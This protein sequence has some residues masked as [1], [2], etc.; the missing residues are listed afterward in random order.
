MTTI[1]S[2][3]YSN[4]NNRTDRNID[5]YFN[6]GIPLL[7]A[8][9]SKIIF[10]DQE[11]YDKIYTYENENTRI[12][13]TKKEDIYLYEYTNMLEN[14]QL[15]TTYPVKDTIEY[16]FIMCNKTESIRKAIELNF[17]NTENFTWIDFGI[18]HVFKNDT[19]EE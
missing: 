8:N 4:V 19:D 3:F 16:M 18:K 13:L 9:I 10:T 1:V 17:F 6:Y 11:M 15:N 2:S 7:K 14:F 5:N 12:I